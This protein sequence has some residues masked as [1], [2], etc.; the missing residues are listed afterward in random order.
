MTDDVLISELR[1]L[2]NNLD[3]YN[4]RVV[5]LRLEDFKAMFIEQMRSILA[6]EGRKAFDTDLSRVQSSAACETRAPC[7]RQLSEM[8]E[9]VIAKLQ[10]DDQR[11]ALGLLDG[12]E[13]LICGEDTPCKDGGCS[14]RAVETIRSVKTILFVYFVLRSRLAVE[15]NGLQT[16]SP[17]LEARPD[18]EVVERAIGPLSN[19]WRISILRMLLEHERTLTE[20]GKVLKM[21][22]GHLQF[23]IRSLRDAGYI[24]ADRRRR[25]YS[26]TPK[27][28]R[29]LDGLDQLMSRLG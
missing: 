12:T 25:V 6:A 14:K 5:R 2:R 15:A 17:S 16:I 28:E 11:G 18:P 21:K 29:A 19:A 10:R 7:Q 9:A 8:M 27:G 1:S 23:H 4:E 24:T 20:I 3:E 22:T 13:Q 26:I